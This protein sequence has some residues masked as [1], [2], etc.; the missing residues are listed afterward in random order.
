MP[1]EASARRYAQAIFELARD[2]NDFDRWSD[3]LD[4]LRR[5]ATRPELVAYL[6]SSQVTLEAKRA[7]LEG[8]IGA[9]HP[10]SV[11]FGLLLSTRRR[12]QDV[13]AIVAEFH[14]LE[15]QLLGIE[16]AQVT[17]AVPL[18][19][20]EATAIAEHL[21][22]ITGKKITLEQKVD[23][24]IIGGIVAR[25]GDRLIDGSVASQLAALRRQLS[26]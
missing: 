10:L 24:E 22:S 7:L 15:N 26:R 23:P 9:A 4:I 1:R 13:E 16:V 20:R 5:V 19:E 25:V 6:Q 11:N 14:R 21:A 2:A 12:L 8:L 18:D 17:T 3:A